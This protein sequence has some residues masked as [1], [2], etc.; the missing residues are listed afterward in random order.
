MVEI[1]GSDD[2]SDCTIFEGDKSLHKIRDK[3]YLI[4]SLRHRVNFTDLD[5]SLDLESGSSRDNGP[6]IYYVLTRHIGSRIDITYRDIL[7]AGLLVE[8][9]YIYAV[10]F[11]KEGVKM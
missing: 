9:M 1:P 2:P 4:D 10:C 7:S 8:R 11:H 6:E 5:D 3:K